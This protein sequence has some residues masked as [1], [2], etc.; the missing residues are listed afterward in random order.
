MYQGDHKGR[1]DNRIARGALVGAPVTGIR[2]V[3]RDSSGLVRT[4]FP[5]TVEPIR[6]RAQYR[7]TICSSFLPRNQNRPRKAISIT[8]PTP[9]EVSLMAFSENWPNA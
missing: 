2:W 3:G 7:S 4:E 9:D 8:V 6:L 1:P 5:L